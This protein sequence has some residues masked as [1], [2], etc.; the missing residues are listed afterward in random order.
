[1][2]TYLQIDLLNEPFKIEL[3]RKVSLSELPTING[4]A[5]KNG[6]ECHR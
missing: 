2:S 6:G 1:M 5:S 4:E 3:S